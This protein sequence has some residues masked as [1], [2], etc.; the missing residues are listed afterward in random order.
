MATKPENIVSASS[1]GISSDTKPRGNTVVLSSNG[2]FKIA[3]SGQL[4][5][6]KGL[7][8]EKRTYNK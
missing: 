7:S 5:S 8:V 2:R 1:S 6:S 4:S 3:A